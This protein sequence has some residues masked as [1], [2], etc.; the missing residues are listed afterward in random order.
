ML[1]LHYE[2][3]SE[4]RVS[5]DHMRRRRSQVPKALRSV[6]Y[7]DTSFLSQATRMEYICVPSCY[8]T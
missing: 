4:L 7:S 6:Q 3:G 1:V 5:F 8:G 2:Y